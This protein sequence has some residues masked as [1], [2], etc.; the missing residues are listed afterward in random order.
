M[1]TVA[2]VAGMSPMALGIGSGG[3]LRAPMA[4]VVMGGLIS[5][6]L[7]TLFIVPVAYDFF[8]RWNVFS[9]KNEVKD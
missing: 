6:M 8:A 4:L 9:Q 2:M 7:L 3:P 5:S 1:T